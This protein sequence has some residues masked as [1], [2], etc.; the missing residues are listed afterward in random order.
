MPARNGYKPPTPKDLAEEEWRLNTARGRRY[1]P[2]HP[3]QQMMPLLLGMDM[4]PLPHGP[5][6]AEPS[7]SPSDPSK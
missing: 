4:C 2:V 6:E 7:G 1:C 3:D 5:A